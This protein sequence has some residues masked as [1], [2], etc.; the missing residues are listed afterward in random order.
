MNRK[1]VTV[2]AAVCFM[3]AAMGMA[4]FCTGA[5]AGSL[6]IPGMDPHNIPG[7]DPHNIPG[8][9]PHNIPG[10]DPHNIPGMDPH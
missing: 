5:Q 3:S 10:M 4:V 8:M 9:D 6:N 7:M 2:A 1:M